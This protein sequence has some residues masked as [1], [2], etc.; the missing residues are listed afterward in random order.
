MNVFRMKKAWL[1]M[2]VL[3]I[4]SLWAQSVPETSFAKRFELKKNAQGEVQ[5]ILDQSLKLNFSVEKVVNHLAELINQ[6]KKRNRSGD[7]YE[8]ELKEI[9]SAN[10]ERALERG[11]LE[12][13][14]VL[15]DALLALQNV[16]LKKMME[17]PK[18]KKIL[19]QFNADMEKALAFIDPRIVAAPL[20]STF[21]YKKTVSYEAVTLGLK[22]AKALLG[23][24]PVLNTISYILVESEKMIRERR[25]YHQNMLLHYLETY[26]ESTLGLSKKEA[27]YAFSSIYESQI[28]WYGYMDSKT[29]MNNWDHFGTDRFF[30][31]YRLATSKL[32]DFSADYQAL[33][34]RVSFSFSNAELDGEA[35]ILNL[36]NTQH[37]F[38]SRP[39]VAYYYNN[40][41]KVLRQRAL[42][43]LAELGLSFITIPDFIKELGNGFL[44]SYYDE[45]RITEGALHAYFESNGMDELKKNLVLQ[46][47]NPFLK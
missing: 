16:D 12:K 3:L 45:H 24:I 46:N 15:K 29:A 23:E 1:L 17:T 5:Y 7:D 20:E 32:N 47:L 31:A 11:D 38:N 14:K 6:E 33:G 35:V 30:T 19:N 37:M 28:P 42:L 41:N 13:I 2:T 21:Y 40:K 27:D 22:A 10:G 36:V 4:N 39:A 43:R 25:Q 8:K 26:P 9:F 34:K 18:A 44:R